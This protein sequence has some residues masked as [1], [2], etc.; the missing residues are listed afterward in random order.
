MHARAA[1]F[2]KQW[3]RISVLAIALAIA[4]WLWSRRRKPR[5][6]D[7]NRSSLIADSS[8]ELFT[9]VAPSLSAGHPASDEPHMLSESERA[10]IVYKYMMI[11]LR[12]AQLF[13]L[14]RI[15]MGHHPYMFSC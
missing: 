7:E 12:R 13:P 6:E 3:L 8:S 14:Y 2:Y 4:R 15:L 11:C 1:T 9:G 5:I 10:A